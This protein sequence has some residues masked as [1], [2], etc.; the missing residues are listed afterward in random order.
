MHEFSQDPGWFY[1]ILIL[2]LIGGAV[3]GYMQVKKKLYGG[4]GPKKKGLIK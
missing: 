1:Y 4:H 3:F 2:A